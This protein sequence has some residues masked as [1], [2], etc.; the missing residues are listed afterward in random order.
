MKILKLTEHQI[1]K[2]PPEK[3]RV[4]VNSG[5]HDPWDL[6]PLQTEIKELGACDYRSNCECYAV[7]RFRSID[8]L[9]VSM[10][11][12]RKLF[13][14]KLE[15][16]KAYKT[17][18]IIVE[19]DY[20]KFATGKYDRDMLLKAAKA[21]ITSWEI[22]YGVHVNFVGNRHFAEDEAYRFFYYSNRQD[23]REKGGYAIT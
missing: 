5:E 17:V 15:Q 11:H 16:L 14:E 21:T 7:V 23:L 2:W 20:E 9:I 13:E 18:Q 12:D 3:V 8:E 1:K 6:S 4:F 22:Q 19:A 10:S